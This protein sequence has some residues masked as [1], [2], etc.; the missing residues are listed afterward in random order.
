MECAGV[1]FLREKRRLLVRLT[2]IQRYE[3]YLYSSHLQ[4]LEQEVIREYQ[5]V[6]FQKSRIQ[7]FPYGDRNT[8]FYHLSTFVRINRGK[9]T[10]LQ[11]DGLWVCGWYCSVLA[12]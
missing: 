5:E 6:L 7:C 1:V 8:R 11:I 10:R 9:I 4:K 12:W 2:G 3:A